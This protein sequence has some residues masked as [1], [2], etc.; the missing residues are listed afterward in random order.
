MQFPVQTEEFTICNTQIRQ[1]ESGRFNLLDLHR[2]AGGGSNC[3]PFDWL[4]LQQTQD[5][6]R[7]LELKTPKTGIPV[8]EK[9]KDLAPINVVKG[10]NGDQGTYVCKHLVY[11]YAMWISSEF[12]MLVIDTFDAVVTGKLKS[13]DKEIQR[14]EWLNNRDELSH[15]C[16]KHQ[17]LG[18]IADLEYE[19]RELKDRIHSE[20]AEAASQAAQTTPA[21]DPREGTT[22]MINNLPVA[23]LNGELYVGAAALCRETGMSFKAQ[24][25]SKLYKQQGVRMKAQSPN[26][27]RELT[28]LPVTSLEQKTQQRRLGS[29]AKDQLIEAVKTLRSASGMTLH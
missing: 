23:L 4:R 10:F 13:L 1:D 22:W 17:L 20:P 27:T 29:G 8:S 5:Y 2:A 19:V 28:M 14:M 16:E 21:A 3:R 11:D 24:Q 6:I 25:A 15:V 26:G 12:R 9:I 7:L 18:Q